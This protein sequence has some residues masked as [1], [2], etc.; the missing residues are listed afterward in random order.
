[1]VKVRTEGVN[2]ASRQEWYGQERCCRACLRAGDIARCLGSESPSATEDLKA[3]QWTLGASGNDRQ[4]DDHAPGIKLEGRTKLEQA[5]RQAGRQAR[6]RPK[7]GRLAKNN[8]CSTA[9]L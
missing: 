2:S 5:G 7:T 4:D 8:G 6:S 1:V 9:L 3:K